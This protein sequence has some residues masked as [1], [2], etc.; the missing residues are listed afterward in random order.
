MKVAV[1]S[2]VESLNSIAQLH[3]LLID[4]FYVTLTK[5]ELEKTK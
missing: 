4:T 1:V 3:A 2:Y 5:E